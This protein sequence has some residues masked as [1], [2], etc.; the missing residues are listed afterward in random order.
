MSS[1][2]QTSNFQIIGKP[3][4]AVSSRDKVTGRA[5]YTDD[6]RIKNPLFVRILRSQ[7]ASANILS[8]DISK[9]KALSGV[10]AIL[11]VS[12]FHRTFGVLP[13]SKDEPSLAKN[14]VRYFGEPVAAVAA[15]TAEVAARALDLIE[16]Q[17]EENPDCLSL[18]EGLKKTD[19][20]IHP[21]LKKET[22]IH[23]SVKQEF[24]NIQEAFEKA[25]VVVEANYTFAPSP[26][27]LQSPM[28]CRLRL[29]LK[30]I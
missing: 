5:Q 19:H 16:V 20:P 28:P 30:I 2:S 8:I 17:Y 11:T 26:M 3:T 29:T 21:E 15:E 6:I 22:N 12:D 18:Q 27:A 25:P 13:I 1:I 24:G 9:A 14:R 23:K 10:R 7:K 4:P